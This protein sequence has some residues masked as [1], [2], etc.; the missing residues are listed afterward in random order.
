MGSTCTSFNVAAFASG[1]SLVHPGGDSQFAAK[2]FEVGHHSTSFCKNDCV[3]TWYA[4]S[5]VKTSVWG[6]MISCTSARHAT[7]LST[8]LQI[9]R[10]AKCLVP[11]SAKFDTP[12]IFVILT[13][14]SCVS[15]CT[16]NVGVAMCRT[17][18]A[19]RRIPMSRPADA[20]T[21]TCSTALSI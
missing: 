14:P 1:L 4:S 17:I 20:S 21:L 18:P 3:S 12:E 19:P 16:R 10:P 9:D 5:T 15:F 2:N 13:L 6:L 7:S 11:R 8:A